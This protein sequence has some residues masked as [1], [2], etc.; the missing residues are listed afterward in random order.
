MTETA[1][2]VAASSLD[3]SITWFAN[4]GTGTFS[5]QPITSNA[6]GVTDVTVADLDRDGDW[7]LVS[8]NSDDNVVAW[9]ENDGNQVFSPHTITLDAGGASATAVADI[10][11]AGRPDIAWT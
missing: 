11:F 3:D 2:I 1:L 4:D 9:F 10:D 7:D 6:G 8:A 5:P